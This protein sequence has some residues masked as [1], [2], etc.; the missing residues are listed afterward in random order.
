MITIEEE[1]LVSA[2]DQTTGT[3]N[4]ID[5]N[6]QSNPNDN[7]SGKSKSIWVSRL[8]NFLKLLVFGLAVFIYDVY[9]KFWFQRTIRYPMI[10]ICFEVK[11]I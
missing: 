1:P 10:D 6:V 11:L 3:G 2:P 9:S 8:F 7:E 4:A 5:T